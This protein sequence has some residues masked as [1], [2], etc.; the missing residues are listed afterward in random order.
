[1]L[2]TRRNLIGTLL[3]CLLIPSFS[4]ISILNRVS[5]VIYPSGAGGT[6]PASGGVDNR[7]PIL[8]KPDGSRIEKVYKPSERDIKGLTDLYGGALSAKL[9]LL[10]DKSNPAKSIFDKLR[11]KDKDSGCA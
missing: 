1:M 9:S 8:L 2:V 11:K 10:N 3:V 7:A 6:G 4:T 5:T